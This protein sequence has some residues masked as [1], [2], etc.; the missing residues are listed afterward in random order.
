MADSLSAAT[1]RR[2]WPWIAAAG[3]YVA[4][5]CLVLFPLVRG[6]GSVVSSPIDDPILSAWILWWDTHAVP[7]TNAWWNAPIFYPTPGTMAF[8][9]LML[10]LVPITGPIQWLSH[11]PVLAYNIAV[12]VSYPLCA[13]SAYALA[14]ELTERRDAAFLAGLA[15]GFSPYRASELGHVQMLSYYWAPIALLALHRYARRRHV[16][17]LVV[18][19]A[20]CLM[21]TLC[22]GYALFQLPVLVVLWAI[23]FARTRR[24]LF[25]VGAALICGLLPMA[26]I[27]WRYREIQS[28]LH[29]QRSIGEITTFSADIASLFSAHPEAI[30]LGHVLTWRQSYALFPGLT[31]L[32]V[33]TIAWLA[34]P[35]DTTP[36]P[37]RMSTGR[38]ALAA[39]ASIC[40]AI[41]AS[42]LIVGP[43]AI[44]PITVS[45]AHK[46]MSIGVVA[47]VL[48]V[49]TGPW[50]RRTWRSRSSIAFYAVAAAA[51]Y[52]LAL[53]P[54]PRF[55]DTPVLYKA[56]YAWLMALPG[57]DAIRAPDRF[58]MLGMLCV[59][60]VFACAYARWKPSARVRWL[61]LPI[62]AGLVV[63]GLCHVYVRPIPAPGPAVSWPSVSAVIE[64]PMTIDRNVAAMYRSIA[65]GV[66]LVNGASGYSA[67]Q[68]PAL[69]AALADG[70][71]PVLEHLA[72]AG[73]L[74][75]AVDRTAP[76][77][78]AIEASL[79]LMKGVT[80]LNETPV[81]ATYV[82]ARSAPPDRG[83]LDPQLSVVAV[84]ANRHMEELPQLGDGRI[85]T[86]WNSGAQRGGEELVVELDG[87]HL[88]TSLVLSIGSCPFGFPRMLSVEASP[89][90][91]VW[92]RATLVAGA[93]GAI[94]AALDNPSD[95]P[96][97]VLL[98][99]AG[100]RFLRLRQL[101][102]A[103][104]VPWCVS[105][106]SVHGPK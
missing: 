101:V 5:A 59:A 56:P 16:R 6:L 40:G 42:V 11:N 103:G 73:P 81:W 52:V 93:L 100:T 51:C 90:G 68:Y 102:D 25:A 13:M 106:L 88:V 36:A 105:D 89:D 18:C 82:L 8:S 72:T 4:L 79:S 71:F 23:W 35:R 61:W 29:L 32:I 26:P 76:K 69:E 55:L 27:L 58:A 24:D 10:G 9:E 31:I 78:L 49:A 83:P 50:W 12:V 66:P 34:A 94:P 2:G 67:P 33:L 80:R 1:S 21:Q 91:Q 17:W 95:V 48:F 41:A 99:E 87:P 30:V 28:A 57:F 47:A 84:R 39:V 96:H 60:V 45:H 77:H 38:K 98:Y 20:S 63:D 70:Y 14:Y 46:P 85:D 44:G 43:W 86:A 65:Y 97:R 104:Q 37:T 3:A 19:G 64:L 7:L 15:F 74:G 22:N 92:T 53:G 54:E 75:I 62:G